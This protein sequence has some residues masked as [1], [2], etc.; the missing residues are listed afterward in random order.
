MTQ[1]EL[2]DKYQAALEGTLGA[3]AAHHVCSSKASTKT[4]R[5]CSKVIDSMSVELRR[6]L[7]ELDKQMVVQNDQSN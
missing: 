2:L 1:P 4:L 7:L 6:T 3:I 5:D